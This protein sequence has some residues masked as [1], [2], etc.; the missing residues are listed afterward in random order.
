MRRGPRT[1]AI[2]ACVEATW[3]D[4]SKR[5]SGNR[6]RRR[7][8]R[9]CSVTV[10]GGFAREQQGHVWR[11]S[12]AIEEKTME[13]MALMQ[14][15]LGPRGGGR[16]VMQGEPERKAAERRWRPDATSSKEPRTASSLHPCKGRSRSS[17]TWVRRATQ[18]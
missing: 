16:T 15:D 10:T 8:G 2:R 3:Q 5:G 9:S 13:G 18:D 1:H 7:S 4:R 17:A 6:R 12:E 11:T 14:I